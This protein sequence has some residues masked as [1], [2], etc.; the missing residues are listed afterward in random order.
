MDK[1]KIMKEAVSS[2][3]IDVGKKMSDPGPIG[4]LKKSDKYYPSMSLS[5][6]E[7]P[8]LEDCKVGST[9]KLIIEVELTT[10]EEYQSSSGKDSS[11][12]R[13]D[14]KKVGLAN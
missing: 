9:K 3:M 2:K 8:W 6:K 14:I 7:V 1:K 12:Y 5:G 4:I 10:K 13:F 11:E